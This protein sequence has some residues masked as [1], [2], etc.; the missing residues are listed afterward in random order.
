MGIPSIGAAFVAPFFAA[1]FFGGAFFAAAFFFL[2]GAAYFF[3]SAFFS[4]ICIV[5]PGIDCA[6]AGA[7]WIASASALAAAINWVFT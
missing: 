6:A 3:G 5:M 7:E 1:P 4:G 2:V